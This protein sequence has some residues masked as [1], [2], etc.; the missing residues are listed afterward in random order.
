MATHERQNNRD[1]LRTLE[2]KP[3]NSRLLDP[4]QALSVVGL[5]ERAV[6]APAAW[7]GGQIA[8]KSATGGLR[9][10]EDERWKIP[11]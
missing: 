3:K 7:S 8:T 6:A 2:K 1:P 10:R 5:R 9:R 11:D 4:P